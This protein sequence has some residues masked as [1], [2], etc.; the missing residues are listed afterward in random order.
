MFIE[1]EDLDSFVKSADSMDGGVDSELFKAT[2]KDCLYKPKAEL[3]SSLDPYSAEYTEYMLKLYQEITGKNYDFMVDEKTDFVIAEHL[4]TP[5]AYGKRS[6]SDLAL[7]YHRISLAIRKANL[8]ISANILDMGCGWG[9]SCEL[10]S[11]FN[12]H[13][14]AIDIN[15]DFVELV[16]KRA[17]RFN[18]KI[19]AETLDFHSCDNL[20]KKFDC[21]FFYE[22]F[23]H[24]LR[25]W[26]LLEKIYNLLEVD[27]KIIFCGEPIQWSDHYW[28]HWGLRLDLLSIYCIKKLGWFESGWSIDFFMDMATRTGYFPRIFK[29]SDPAVGSVVICE[30]SCSGFSAKELNDFDFISPNWIVEGNFLISKGDAT[31]SF[32]LP[33]KIS[34][35]TIYCF[36]FRGKPLKIKIFK[37]NKKFIDE[38]LSPGENK[39]II[40][41]SIPGLQEIHFISE[42]WNPNV[43]LLNNDNRDISF[44]LEKITF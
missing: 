35:I 21:V 42:K 32:W 33:K 6:P 44:H 17:V 36:N 24:D 19:K 1:K 8:R 2:Y 41:I 39:F 5:N 38:T 28:Q 9:L 7:A 13:V 40:P 16:N 10:F 34:E 31:L 29:D 3:K 22:S 23:H 30:K 15:P 4:M 27:G 26:A 12:L 43:E 18:Y 37:N 14:T 20:N 25:P 11:Q